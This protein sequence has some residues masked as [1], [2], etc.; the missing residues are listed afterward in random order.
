MPGFP[1]A[2]SAGA[3]PRNQRRPE[4][5]AARPPHVDAGDGEDD[6]KAGG[7]LDQ[8][9]ARLAEKQRAVD[10]LEEQVPAAILRHG[11]QHGARIGIDG[12][13]V[14]DLAHRHRHHHRCCGVIRRA[15]VL[16]RGLGPEGCARRLGQRG[17]G[18]RLCLWGN[19]QPVAMFRQVGREQHHEEAGDGQHEQEWNNVEP[20]IEVP[21]PDGAIE[22]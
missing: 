10:L 16:H 20:G 7:D 19:R 8:P 3:E 9:V 4:A 1:Q 13:D 2:A 6:A 14:T 21:A 11:P 15:D 22:A 17:G 12:E 5:L 18:K